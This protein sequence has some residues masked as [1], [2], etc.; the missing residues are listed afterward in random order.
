LG[1]QDL[2]RHFLWG[3]IQDN[4]KVQSG[5]QPA[6]NAFL[7]LLTCYYLED[8]KG[9]YRIRKQM[10]DFESKSAL[11]CSVLSALLVLQKSFK[12]PVNSLKEEVLSFREENGGFKATKATPIPDLLSTAVALYALNYAGYDLSAIRP[13][14]FEFIDSLYVDGGFGG[15]VFDS[16]PD[17]EYTFYGLLALGALA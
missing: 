8:Y 17:M 3:K 10:K 14:S 6:Y 9:L 4:L 11:P 5:K 13:S 7:N 1:R 15:N 12:K 2:C 16:D